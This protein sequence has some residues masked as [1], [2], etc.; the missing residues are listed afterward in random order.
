MRAYK[1]NAFVVIGINGFTY[2]NITLYSQSIQYH[3]FSR[4]LM[5]KIKV[6]LIKIHIKFGVQ[7]SEKPFMSN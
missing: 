4:D 1:S 2:I 6:N 3:I 7:L 5:S